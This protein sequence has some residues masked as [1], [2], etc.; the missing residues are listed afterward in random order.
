[1]IARWLLTELPAKESEKKSSDH[2]N[3]KSTKD[4]TP[5]KTDEKAKDSNNNNN[6]T[7]ENG[8]IELIVG[9]STDESDNNSN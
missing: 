4:Y 1:M 9:N 5:V 7:I 2:N 3:N 8:E 6:E